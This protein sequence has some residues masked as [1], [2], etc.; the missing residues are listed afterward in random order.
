MDGLTALRNTL[1]KLKKK[2]VSSLITFLNAYRKESSE[3]ALKSIRLVKLLLKG[4]KYTSN[5]IQEILYG[6]NN[7][8]AFNKLV[9]RLKEK[10]REVLIFD[11]NLMI[12]NHYGKRNQTVF[13]IRKKLLQSE[14]MFYRGMNDELENFL[15][16]IIKKTKEYEI[17]DSLLAA[18]DIKQ[19]YR[20]FRFGI[21]RNGKLKNEIEFYTLIRDKLIRAREIFY[22]LTAKINFSASNIEYQIELESSL[23]LLQSDYEST[24]SP[25]I[26]YYYFLLQTEKYQNVNDLLSAQNILSKLVILVRNSP[27]VY[28][29]YTL[30]NTLLNFGNNEL[31]MYNFSSSESNFHEAI[32]YSGNSSVNNAVAKELRF[33][34]LFFS[35]QIVQSEKLIEEL[36]HASRTSNT[37]FLYSKRAYL[38]ACVKTL[39]RDFEA[40][41]ELLKEVK[42]IEKDK[43][44]WNIGVR[45]L[46]CMNWIELE[47]FEKADREIEKLDRHII[48]TM[49]TKHVRK[50]DI[51]IKDILLQLM[52]HGYDFKKC[53]KN[54]QNNFDLL[55]SVDQEYRWKIKS[56]EMLI[57]Q[58]WFISKVENRPY[59]LKKSI[60]REKEKNAPLM[61]G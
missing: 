22:N 55:E 24:K 42:E 4:K 9:N 28:T 48:R 12:P 17:Y 49:E 40:S 61:N 15:N 38:L 5:E 52:Q 20:N 50:R 33:H 36:Y 3:E 32:S 46:S 10:I 35:S 1:L 18:L 29:N 34:A 41:I 30:G 47:N 58:E 53:Y 37:P 51:V 21:E 27:S 39:N 45:I 16:K 57:F 56:P 19:R 6:K 23:V 59:N 13:E 31:L 14:I 26:G 25:T 43:E 54:Q 7:Y 2:E 11:S 60:Q 44:G 8:H